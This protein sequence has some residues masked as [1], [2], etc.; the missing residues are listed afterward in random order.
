[1]GRYSQLVTTNVY[2]HLGVTSDKETRLNGL[3]ESTE[4]VFMSLILSRYL[5][6]VTLGSDQR[7][8]VI[9]ILFIFIISTILSERVRGGKKVVASAFG[10]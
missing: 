7:L 3:T 9:F 4:Q 2:D 1:M 5:A 6:C 10:N 8:I